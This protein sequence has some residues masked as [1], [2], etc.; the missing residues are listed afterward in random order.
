V[1]AE[2]PLW[3]YTGLLSLLSYS[4]FMAFLTLSKVVHAPIADVLAALH[5]PVLILVPLCIRHVVDSVDP[6]LYTI[7]DRIKVLWF[8]TETSFKAKFFR[9]DNGIE[10]II[11]AG[12]GLVIKIQWIARVVPE[13][14]EIVEKCSVK[15]LNISV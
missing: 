15:V 1:H 11:H 8:H 6:D 4:P 13:G 9:L 3:H 7:T 10:T 2:L 12:L 5:N 14:T